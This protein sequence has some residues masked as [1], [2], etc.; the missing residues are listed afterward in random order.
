MKTVKQKKQKIFMKAN[1]LQ[2]NLLLNSRVWPGGMVV[3]FTC[4]ALVA[5]ASLVWAWTYTLL[6]K[7]CCGRRPTC[8][9]E[10]DGQGC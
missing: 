4:S 9:I 7:P 2:I 10:E 3:K 6:I 1:M 8:K 5:W